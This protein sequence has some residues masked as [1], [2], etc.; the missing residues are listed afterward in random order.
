MEGCEKR[1]VKHEKPVYGK[2]RKETKPRE[3]DCRPKNSGGRELSP[4][5]GGYLAKPPVEEKNW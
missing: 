4:V 2:G 5:L 1:A 3:T